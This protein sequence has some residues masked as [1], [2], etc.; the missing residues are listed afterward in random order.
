MKITLQK[1][2]LVLGATKRL[3]E[4]NKEREL[5]VK[6]I[7]DNSA[8]PVVNL[9]EPRECLMKQEKEKRKKLHWTQTP[10]GKRKMSRV[11]KKVW[12][13]GRSGIQKVKR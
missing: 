11:Q 13:E 4:L 5:L 3:E 6:I 10:E 7:N 1:E 9:R 12:R 2:L 8:V